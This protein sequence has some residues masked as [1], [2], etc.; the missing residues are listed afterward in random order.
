MTKLVGQR[1]HS[2]FTF[3]TGLANNS[4]YK[5]KVDKKYSVFPF[6]SLKNKELDLLLVP[7]LHFIYLE[8]ISS[9]EGFPGFFNTAQVSNQLVL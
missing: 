6:S 1:R 3:L 5:L 8:I 2:A 9:L 7:F 4:L